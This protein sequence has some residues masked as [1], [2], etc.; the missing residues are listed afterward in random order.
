MFGLHLHW[1]IVLGPSQRVGT[2]SE[3]ICCDS[4]GGGIGSCVVMICATSSGD[5]AT[6]A[7]HLVGGRSLESTISLIARQSF[8][9]SV[10]QSVSSQSID[11]RSFNQTVNLYV[12]SMHPCMY[13]CMHACVHA[14]MD[15]VC[16]CV[17]VYVCM[18]V[19]VHVY[20]CMHACMYVRVQ[21]FRFCTLII[22][23]LN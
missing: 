17:C 16:V 15:A 23:R 6:C 22:G 21:V 1:L 4:V 19:C 9:R 13:V 3:R 12:H 20:A 5:V 11:C 18:Y 10:S 14:C 8:H 2:S 7:K